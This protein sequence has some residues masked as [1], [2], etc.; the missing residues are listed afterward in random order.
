MI[1]KF[2]RYGLD[3]KQR[4]LERIF[5]V[6]PGVSSWFII[7]AMFLLSFL[8]PF[9]SAVII[10]AFDLYWLFKLIFMTILLVI[11]YIRLSIENETDWIERIHNIDYYDEYSRSNP[12]ITF[13]LGFKKIISMW[14]HFH[15]I[16]F[17]YKSTNPPV[18]SKDIFHLVILPI[19]KETME[20]IEPAVSSIAVG[21]FS[22]KQIL[23]IMALEDRAE[24]Q[25][26]EDARQVQK[27]FREKFLDLLIVTHPD[28]I[29]G[30]AAVKGANVTCAAKEAAKYFTENKIPFE[31]VIVSCF[32][33]DT[34]VDPKYFSCLTYNFMVHPD[35]AR[36]SFQ[37]I[38]VYHNNIWEVPAFA[39]VLDVGS[40]FFQL[41]EATN[42]DTLVTF[43]SHSMSF[44]ALV[45]IGY[46]P[47]D[48]ISDDSAIFWKAF[49]HYDGN[50]SVVPLY[51]T[52][53]MD[54]AAGPSW[55]KTLVNVYKQ[56]R[57][58]AWGV[59]NFPIVMRAF[60][61]AHG[62]S[63]YKRCRHAFRLL[64]GH[65]AWA[66]WP[67]LLGVI[68]WFPAFFAS[69]EF[70]SSVLYY[71]AP[72]VKFIIFN[73]ASIGFFTTIILSL[74]LL[75]KRNLKQTIFK[76]IGHI[77]EW[78]LIPL[79]SI[80]LSAVPALDAQTRLMFGRYMEFWVTPKEKT[81]KE[82]D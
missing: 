11:S 42:P 51:I 64:E 70:S 8:K 63:F 47:V 32:D 62:I 25:I 40:S 9:I 78:L 6:I 74:S 29:P 20:I 36:A 44:K 80:F 38:P 35:R 61:Q 55:R 71:S 66:T 31:N 28:G 13:N 65:I 30:E 58:W 56:K 26:Q 37:P 12:S 22:S 2:S 60:L 15:Q 10:I 5:E 50:Y 3:K 72:R 81:Y 21:Q 48:I 19:A 75:P 39:R 79:I 14:I 76:K 82:N 23:L 7:I 18:P 43:S 27:K 67:F 73:L 68:G 1:F 52:V 45:D 57:R 54:I 59:E 41:I 24:V 34:V 17:L 33:A 46:W 4:T 53:S 16:K 69:R 49:I 77:F